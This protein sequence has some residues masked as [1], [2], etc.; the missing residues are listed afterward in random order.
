MSLEHVMKSQVESG[1][2]VVA[3]QLESVTEEGVMGTVKGSHLHTPCTTLAR[4]L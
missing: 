1:V 3:E 2:L 4:V